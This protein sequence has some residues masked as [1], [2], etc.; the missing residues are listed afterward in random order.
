MRAFL[1]LL[2]TCLA[3]FPLFWIINTAMT[4][5]NDLYQGQQRIIPDISRTF[6]LFS[7][8]T[9]DTPFLHWMA[10]SAVVAFGTTFLSLIL[11]TMAAY[12]LSRYKFV[13]KGPM[14]F[15]FFATQMLPEALLVVPLYSL[16]AALGLLN[17][18]GGLVLVNTAFAMPVALFILKSAIDNIPF[19]LEE[20]A[21]VD[22]CSPLSILQVMVVPLVAPSMA[23]A[24]V[25]TFFDGWNEYLFATTFIRDR[26]SWVASTG[27]A[28][29]IGEFS[30]PLDTVFS[31]ALVFTVPAVVFFLLMQRKIVSGLTAGSVKG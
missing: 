7:V 1:A 17:Q 14:G 29:F 13:G 15:L 25:I 2:L 12:A 11:A 8:L 9:T 26:S 16:F 22:G 5:T 27:L 18:L 30:T 21:R 3:G 4:P 24:A 20:S 28:S 6:G 19:E 31:A 10:N 23:A